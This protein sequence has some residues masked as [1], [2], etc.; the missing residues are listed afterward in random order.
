MLD[1]DFAETVRLRFEDLTKRKEQELIY[2]FHISVKANDKIL[3]LYIKLVKSIEFIPLK[4]FITR[5]GASFEELG[6]SD[7]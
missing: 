2:N 5:E 6:K 1:S 7:E 3:D 4:S